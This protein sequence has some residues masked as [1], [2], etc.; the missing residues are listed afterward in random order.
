VVPRHRP[1]PLVSGEWRGDIELLR[2]LNEH[3]TVAGCVRRGRQV[4]LERRRSGAGVDRSVP[5]RT[6]AACATRSMLNRSRHDLT[7]AGAE[8]VRKFVEV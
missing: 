4:A 3:P 5:R 6:C 7:N 1:I 8:V 2:M